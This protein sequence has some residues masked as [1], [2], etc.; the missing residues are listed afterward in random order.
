MASLLIVAGPNE[1]D[2]YPLKTATVVIGRGENCPIQIRDD[3]VSRRHLQIRH[4]DGKHV[5]FDMKSTNGVWI[6]N[7]Q[8][9]GEVELAD[10]DEILLGD[11]K[12]VY[13]TR[14]F[15]DRESAMSHFKQRGE[16]MRPTIEQ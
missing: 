4:N 15:E 7:R 13:S 8:M 5:A 12:I 3:R 9:G 2:Y 1:G 10:N 14:E 11:T 16:R 6:N